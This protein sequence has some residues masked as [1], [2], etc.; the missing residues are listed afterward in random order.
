DTLVITLTAVCQ[1]IEK[2]KAVR[3]INAATRRLSFQKKIGAGLTIEEFKH[4][5]ASKQI[6]GHVGL[7]Q[8][9][10]MIADALS[11]KLDGIK[12]DEVEPVIAKETVES[13]VVKVEAGKVVGLKQ[14]ARGFMKGREVILL[15]FQAYIGAKEEYD[16]ITIHGVPTVRQKIQPCIHGDIGTAAVVIN[17]IPKVLKAHAG[18][19]TMKDLQIPSA[20]LGDL[21]E[22]VS[23]LSFSG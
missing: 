7:E 19:L 12:A 4:K 18:L 16:A 13:S 10:A 15:D 14:T 21:R 3:V 20:A 8:S 6:T 22:H 23:T 11:W 2:I 5:I 17:S 9:I 1:K